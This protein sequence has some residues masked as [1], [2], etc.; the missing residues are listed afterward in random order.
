MKPLL[1]RRFIGWGGNLKRSVNSPEATFLLG[2]LAFYPIYYGLTNSTHKI[3]SQ[4]EESRFLPRN[5][6]GHGVD[7]IAKNGSV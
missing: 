3:Q 5:P 4:L 2:D 1:F 7:K 6:C